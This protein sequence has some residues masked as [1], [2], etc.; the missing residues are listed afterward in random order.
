MKGE[1]DAWSARGSGWVLERIMVAYVNVA[2]YQPLRGGTYL[3][4]PQKL[5]SKKAII[6]V[7]NKDSECLKGALRATLYPAPKGKISNRP[8]SY[9]VVDGIN[10]KVID[11][12]TPVKQIDKLESQNRNLAINVFAW[13]ND[14]VIVH[15]ISRKGVKAPRINLLLIESGEKQRY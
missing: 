2:R 5:K 14:C 6:N 3:D 13:E 1:I 12:S 15:R 4:L 8:S 9:P 10:Y 11:F 7:Q